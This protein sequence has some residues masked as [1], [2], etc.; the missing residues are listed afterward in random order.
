MDTY[1]NEILENF[2][3]N[4]IIKSTYNIALALRTKLGDEKIN[5]L[6]KTL[7]KTFKN[8]YKYYLTAAKMIEI[9]SAEESEDGLKYPSNGMLDGGLWNPLS[10]IGNA[11]N[12]LN[13]VTASDGVIYSKGSCYRSKGYWSVDFDT[14]EDFNHFL[15]AGC[16]RYLP[17]TKSEKW[18]LLPNLGDPHYTEK[19]LRFELHYMKLNASKS[20]MENDFAIMAECIE[21]YSNVENEIKVEIENDKLC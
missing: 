4:N 13:G 15:W 21:D 16:N 14:V 2:E 1:V 10:I 5:S 12:S 8:T 20:D 6:F 17:L 9:D 11:L 3:E 19:K 7:P 18:R